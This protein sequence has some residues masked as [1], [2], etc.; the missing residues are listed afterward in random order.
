MTY[1]ITVGGVFRKLPLCKIS[2]NLQIAAFDMFGDTELIKACAIG[3]STK[4]EKNS[5]NFDIIVTP[6]AKAIPLT[7]DLAYI[8]N[9][10]WIVARKKVKAYMQEPFEVTVKSITTFDTQKLIIDKSKADLILNKKVLIIDDVI[11]TGESLKAVEE[12]VSQAGGII[13]AKAAVLAEG[14]AAKRK[15]IIY[16]NYLPLF[17]AEGNE[18]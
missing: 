3:I 5:I 7:Y 13:S 15:D 11:S 17:D 8:Y 18:I 6:E 14:S 9:K 12:L 2:D 4:L 10:P 1:G 16:L